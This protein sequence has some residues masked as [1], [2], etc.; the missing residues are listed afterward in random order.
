MLSGLTQANARKRVYTNCMKHKR[1]HKDQIVQAC[2]RF[3][4]LYGLF[5]SFPTHR[6]NVSCDD[7]LCIVTVQFNRNRFLS[8]R[9]ATKSSQFTVG[10]VRRQT[11]TEQAERK[12]N[13]H[14]FC[15]M[16]ASHRFSQFTRRFLELVPPYSY[17][18]ARSLIYQSC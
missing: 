8:L 16:L 12:E 10:E 9:C 7:H 1:N 6:H 17:A 14:L 5:R 18:Y 2:W 15:L 13:F 4:C 3:Y 11:L